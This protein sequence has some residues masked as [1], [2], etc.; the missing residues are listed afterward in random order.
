MTETAHISDFMKLDF[1]VGEIVHA[2]QNPKAKKRAYILKI[3][4]GADFG[5]KG[6][7]AQI[8]DNYEVSELIGKKIIA[9][10]NFKSRRI[11]G[12]KSEVLVLAVVSE[13]HGAILIQPNKL[14]DNGSKVL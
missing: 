13:E 4:F 7:S 2:E 9:I 14:V 8:C 1:R 12:F 6:S 3:D 10:I 5:I 11:A